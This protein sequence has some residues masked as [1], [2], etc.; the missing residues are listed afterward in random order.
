MDEFW[1]VVIIAGSCC[2][3]AAAVAIVGNL[4]I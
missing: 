4:G 3:V 1:T 2:A